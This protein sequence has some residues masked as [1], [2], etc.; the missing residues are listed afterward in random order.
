MDGYT[1]YFELLILFAAAMTALM[2]VEYAADQGLAGAEYYALIMFA[3]LGM[4]LMA[5]ADDLIMI[6]LGLETMSIAVYALAGFC[7][8]T[9]APMRPPLSISC[10]ALF[11]PASCS[12]ASR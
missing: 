11:P 5:A 10:S 4:M 6:F 9:R 1:A 12:M 3:A 7:A 2:S 8:A